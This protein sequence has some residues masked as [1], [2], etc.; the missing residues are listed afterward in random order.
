MYPDEFP[1]HAHLCCHKGNGIGMK[2]FGGKCVKTWKIH[3]RANNVG[4]FGKTEKLGKIRML[5]KYE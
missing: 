4:V 1:I 5:L 2:R 3:W